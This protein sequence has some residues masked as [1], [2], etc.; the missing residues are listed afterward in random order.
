MAITGTKAF[1]SGEVL[2]SNDVNQ[3]LMRGV[4]VFSSTA[5]R[6]AAYGGAGEP[7]LEEGEACFVTADSA[8]QVY[9]GTAAGWLPFRRAGAGQVLQVVSTTKTDVSVLSVGTAQTDITGLSVSITPSATSSKIWVTAYVTH[10]QNATGGL[11]LVRDSTN[12]CIGDTASNRIRATVGMNNNVAP[13]NNGIGVTPMWFLDSPN[14]TSATTYKVA[15]RQ[16][17]G[18]TFT[19]NRAT[20]DTDNADHFRTTST[21]TVMEVSA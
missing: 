12:I 19:V 8:F 9:G 21:I 11:F 14:T 5:V 3:Y 2:T 16:T 7:V 10:V 4:K 20:T 17:S 18:G 15:V 6:D 1:T 13:S